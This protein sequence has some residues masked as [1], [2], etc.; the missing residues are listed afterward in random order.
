MD[1]MVLTSNPASLHDASSPE[2]WPGMCY[3]MK[4]GTAPML[5]IQ[6]PRHVIVGNR[7]RTAMI[8]ESLGQ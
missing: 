8:Q 5:V 2:L 4:T 7:I 1:E 6:A 3:A